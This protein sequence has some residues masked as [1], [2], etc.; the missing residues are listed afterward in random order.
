MHAFNEVSSLL[1]MEGSIGK[2]ETIVQGMT[3]FKFVMVTLASLGVYLIFVLALA[4]IF[5]ELKF[6]QPDSAFQIYTAFF[7]YWTRIALK[8]LFF[9]VAYS[10]MAIF[11]ADLPFVLFFAAFYAINIFW[12]WA[13]V[14]RLRFIRHSGWWVLISLIPYVSVTFY[15]YLLFWPSPVAEPGEA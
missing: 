15:L 7:I 14:Q 13:A 12:M 10:F 2:Q 5:P 4:A 8:S 6:G 1:L 11:T 3:R 9:L